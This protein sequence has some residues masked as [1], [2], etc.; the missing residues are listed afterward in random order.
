MVSDRSE[1]PLK[2]HGFRPSE[3]PLKPRGFR[4]SQTTLKPRGFRPLETTLKP[5]GLRP[6]WNHSETTRFET[7][8]NHSKTTR[9]QTLWNP[10][11]TRFQ[12]P[13]KPLWNPSKTTLKPLWNHHWTARDGL[14]EAVYRKTGCWDHTAVSEPSF[15][16]KVSFR[17]VW[18]QCETIR[19]WRRLYEAKQIFF[20]CVCL[21]AS[22]ARSVN[23]LGQNNAVQ[24]HLIGAKPIVQVKR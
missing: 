7:L 11:T 8:W 1:T 9:F 13:L 21:M 6:L 4:P 15:Q 14:R 20:F 3:T 2:P 17:I 5:H 22:M 19:V 12:T 16:K 18:N 24:V 23:C 10:E